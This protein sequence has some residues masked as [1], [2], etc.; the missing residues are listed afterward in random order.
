MTIHHEV[1]V[2]PTPD[3]LVEHLDYVYQPHGT[4][5]LRDVS[6]S[7]EPGEFVAIIGQNGAGKTTLLKNILGLLTPTRG[8]VLVQG[9]DTRDATVA[10]LATRAGLV[11][12]NPDQQL[13]AETVEK[14]VAF[15]PTNLGLSAEE[16]RARTDEAIA[17][18]GLEQQRREFPPALCK[19]DRAKVV[20]AAVLAMR[21]RIILLDEPTTGQDDRGCHQIMEIAR[22]LNKAGHTIVM[23]THY[24]AL[25]AEYAPRTIVM[26]QGE[27]ILDDS[28]RRV[29]AQPHLL[30]RTHLMPPQITQLAQAM[31]EKWGFP[32]DVLTV[33]EMGE[34]ILARREGD[35]SHYCAPHTGKG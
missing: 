14:E 34:R 2:A 21:P 22:T 5:A 16:V 23:V 17:L 35:R 24:M 31:P 3:I 1:K 30:Q 9:L 29:F 10:E 7:I 20:I 26:C 28:T 19:G 6:L 25:V 18:V 27:I 4:V 13:F 32:R 8:R 11:L 33:R 12:Q 15:G